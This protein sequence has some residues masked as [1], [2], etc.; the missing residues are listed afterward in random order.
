MHERID[1]GGDR[2]TADEGPLAGAGDDQRA[3]IR[4]RG[5]PTHRG[6][7]FAPQRTAARRSNADDSATSIPPCPPG[8]LMPQN[9]P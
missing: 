7:E 6:D 4:T 3:Q 8:P 1:A 9:L 5:K 2:G